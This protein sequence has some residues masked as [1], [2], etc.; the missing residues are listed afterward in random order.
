MQGIEAYF[1][2]LLEQQKLYYDE[3]V[4]DFIAK[5]GMKAGLPTFVRTVRETADDMQEKFEKHSDIVYE[6][7]NEQVEKHKQ[8]ISSVKQKV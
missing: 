4:S 7:V 6:T 2:S 1:A 8:R 5:A 3:P